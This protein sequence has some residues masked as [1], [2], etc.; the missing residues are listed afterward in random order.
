MSQRGCGNAAVLLA[1]VSDENKGVRML[2]TRKHT[3]TGVMNVVRDARRLALI[4]VT[5]E[6][7]A[8]IEYK[9]RC[10]RL[11]RLI[12]LGAPEKIV[13]GE[14]VARDDAL[15]GV[16]MATPWAKE[17]KG[18]MQMMKEEDEANERVK[19]ISGLNRAR[20]EDSDLINDAAKE[21]AA[22]TKNAARQLRAH[23]NRHMRAM[24]ANTS[25]Q[26]GE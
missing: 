9:S 5:D 15:I 6:H 12:D 14:K 4:V 26:K 20:K 21:A 16:I 2:N 8:I 25:K 3:H 18:L 7:P 22:R 23:M 1:H 10:H 19:A 17:F 24:C 11:Q 13:K